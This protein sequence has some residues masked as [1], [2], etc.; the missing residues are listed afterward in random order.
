MR[1]FKGRTA[2]IT[3][4]ASGI[5]LAVA[6]RFARE[7]MNVVLAD[8]EQGALAAAEKKL[9]A[10]GANTLAVRTDVAEW[11]SVAA[12]ADRVFDEFGAVHLLCNNAGVTNTRVQAR[13]LWMR[14]LEDWQWVMGVNLWGVIHGVRAF[15][16]RMLPQGEEGQIVNTASIAGILAPNSGIYGVSKHAVVALSETLRAQLALTKA[17]VRVS[18]LCPGVANT[19]IMDAERNRPEHL[20]NA[21]RSELSDEERAEDETARRRLAAGLAPS[22]VADAVIEGIREQ[23]FFI[24]PLQAGHVRPVAEDIRHRADTIMEAVERP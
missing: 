11:D 6:E 15:L 24:I 20:Q 18:V 1:E 17:S 22:E 10:A 21:K 2:V 7:G 3:G 16:P 4:A 5:G 12:L 23:E 13:G 9:Q 14:S 19:N 8:I